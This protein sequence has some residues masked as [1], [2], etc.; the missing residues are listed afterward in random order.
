[1]TAM[2]Q[3][4]CWEAVTKRDPSFD[5]RFVYAVRST[6]IY[7]RPSCPSRPKRRENVVFLASCAAAEAAGFRACKRCRPKAEDGGDPVAWAAVEAVCRL[8]EEA[9]ELPS[10]AALAAKAG[11]SPFYFQRLFKARTGL[12]PK[13]YAMAKR[14]LR[15]RTL[16]ATEASATEAIHA[17]GYGTSSRAYADAQ[18]NALPLRRQDRHRQGGVLRIATVATSLG[19]VTAAASQTGLCMVAFGPPDPARLA[20]RFPGARFEDGGDEM[21]GWMASVVAMIDDPAAPLRHLP[22]D[23]RGTAFQE[24]VWRALTRIAPG[25]TLTYAQLAERVG[26][27]GAARAVAR[28]CATNIVA[29]A[30]PC[31][32]VVGSDGRLTGYRWGIERKRALLD[33]EARAV[34]NGRPS[35]ED[36]KE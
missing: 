5:G 3:E 31:H 34:R 8:I 28:A 6:G 9:E 17:A 32:R 25:T 4:L 23:I 26:R 33:R 7:C 20:E 14:R 24:M 35:G 15:L 36:R 11:Y 27:P 2:D 1:M 12:S 13:Q 21:A 30:V 29:V 18:D 22:L 16:L 19:P 10:L